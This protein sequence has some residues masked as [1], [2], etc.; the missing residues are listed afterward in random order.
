MLTKNM[1]KKDIEEI[2]EGK[3]DFVQIDYLTKYLKDVAPAGM[4]GFAS[5]KL[6]EIYFR[7]EMFID[8]AQMFRNVAVNSVTFKDRQEYF[9][10]EAKTYI[11]A[12]KFED[13]DKALKR[14]LAEGNSREQEEI[15]GKILIFYKEI[16][17]RFIKELKREKASKI[18][19][20]LFRMKL[21]DIEREEIKQKLLDLYEKLGKRKEADF[22]R[23][24]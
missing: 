2:L 3:G 21:N 18:Y 16:G 4:R 20:K 6:A 12:G 1:H 22:L 23:S 24:H 9:L 13:S 15:Y 7:K 5:L 14:A 10:K 11:L 17:E 8:A 19:E